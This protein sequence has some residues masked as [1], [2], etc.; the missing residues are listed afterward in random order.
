[1]PYGDNNRLLFIKIILTALLISP[2]FAKPAGA[3]LIIKGKVISKKDKRIAAGATISLLK[4]NRIVITDDAGDFTFRIPFSRSNDSLVISSVGY[5]ELVIAVTDALKKNQFELTERTGILASVIVRSFTTQDVIG[6]S[7]ESVGYFRNWNIERSGGEIGRV[8]SIPY[9]QYKLDKIRFKVSSLCDTCLIRLHIRKMNNNMPEEDLLKDSISLTIRQLT[10][11]DK[12]PE[13]DLT[14]Y[15]IILDKSAFFV[16]LELV[17]CKH[18][19]K[20]DCTFCFV[21][22]EA[23]TF[24]YRSGGNYSWEE[25]DAFAIYMKIF[26][27]H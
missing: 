24:I 18:P 27:R 9:D 15:D 8:F 6:T 21:G 20:N 5:E 11:D 23:G 26:M 2:V 12:A 1:M 3:Q 25:T 4:R 19:G 14:P 10:L 22:T 16:G 17:N 13:F 7:R